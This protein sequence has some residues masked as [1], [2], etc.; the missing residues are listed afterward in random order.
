MRNVNTDS[1]VIVYYPTNAGG[2]FLINSLGLSNGCYFQDIDFVRLQQDNKFTPKLKLMTL[3]ERIGNNN[4]HSWGDLGLGCRAL[5]G[6]NGHNP[7]DF[8]PEIDLISYESTLFFVVA[9]TPES[10]EQLNIIWP[11]AKKIYLTN[12]AK[13]IEWRTNCQYTQPE[14]SELLKRHEFLIWDVGSYF[15]RSQFL[16]Q[17]KTFYSQLGLTDFNQHYA[18][19]F[20]NKYIEKLI[21]IREHDITN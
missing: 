13:F 20:Y 17:L 5:F 12:Y 1:V 6:T 18:K 21:K 11:N 3:L 14:D 7:E 9:H 15:D 19:T 2:K 16:T 8:F 10:F 4:N